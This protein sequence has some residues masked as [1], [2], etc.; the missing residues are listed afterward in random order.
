LKI[1]RSLDSFIKL[2]NAIITTGTF[3][4]VHKGHVDIIQ[5]LCSKQKGQESVLITFFP[6]PRLVLYPDQE[7]KFLNTFE[8]KINLFSRFKID[9][10]IIQEFTFEFSRI[11]S[12]EYIRDIL[13]KKIGL[14]KLIIGHD[15]HFGRNRESSINQIK[16]FSDLYSFNF[17]EVPPFQSNGVT[18]SSTKIRKALFKGDI[19]AANNFLGYKFNLEGKVIKGKGLGK[20]IGYPTANIQVDNKNKIIP[21]IGVYAVFVELHKNIFRGMLNIGFNPTFNQKSISIE[22]H[23][24]DFKNDIYGEKIK[25]IFEQKIRDEKKFNSI[26]ELK[27]QLTKDQILA[28]KLL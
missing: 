4:G 2:D 22:L 5:E 19:L 27:E 25:V 11:T 17:K 28:Q 9:H 23:I 12:L 16:E 6:H 8:E 1:Y 3:D 21:S 15:H 14:S 20:E 24:F 10:L 13:K 7:L 26:K 18:I